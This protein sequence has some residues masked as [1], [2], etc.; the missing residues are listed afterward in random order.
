[1]RAKN[2]ELHKEATMENR[3]AFGAAQ[4]ELQRMAHKTDDSDQESAGDADDGYEDPYAD[5]D[6]R[7]FV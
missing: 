3:V 7:A 2:Q 6:V 1:M 5:I 4:Y